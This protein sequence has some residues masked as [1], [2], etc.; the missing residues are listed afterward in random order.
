MVSTAFKVMLIVLRGM[1]LC[2]ILLVLFGTILQFNF[3]QQKRASVALLVD[4]SASLQISDKGT[5][6]SEVLQGILQ[7]SSLSDIRQTYTVYPYAFSDK[8]GSVNKAFSDSLSFQGR[9]TDLAR[10]LKSA[11]EPRSGDIPAAIILLSDGR[12][13]I[14]DN[15]ARIAG[16]LNLPVYSVGIGDTAKKSDIVITRVLSNDITYKDNLT[17]CEV[18]FQGYGFGGKKVSLRLKQ[19]GNIL[20]EKK[21][22][23]PSNNLETRVNF[24]FKLSETGINKLTLEVDQFAEELTGENN[25]RDF[26]IKVLESKI[27]ILLLAS[28]PS[29]DLTFLKRLL[30]TD[31]DVEL[32]VRTEKKSGGFYQGRFPDKAAFNQ[33]D[34]FL[35]L[36]FPSG[37][38]SSFVWNMVET[39]VKD[40]QK[41]FMFFAGRHFSIDKINSLQD[42]LPCTIERKLTVT[43]EPPVITQENRSHPLLMINHTTTVSSWNSLPPIFPAC[44]V[45]AIKP[46]DKVLCEFGE[47][48]SGRSSFPTK[49]LILVHQAAGD[50][51]LLFL[52]YGFYRWDLVMWGIGKTNQ[53]LQGF[54]G[55]ALRWLSVQEDDDR[56]I[57]KT[58]KFNFR[59]GEEVFFL[60]QAYD[61]AYEPLRG[62][63]VELSSTTPHTTE[64]L[65]LR[66]RGDGRYSE[67]KRFF[68][69]GKYTVSAEVYRDDQIVGKD[70]ESFSVDNFNPEFVNTR[71]DFK[72]LKSVSSLSGGKFFSIHNLDSLDQ[73][74]QFEPEQVE[75]TR[76][77]EFFQSPWV[78]VV[79]ILL[80]SLDWFL[81][82]RKGML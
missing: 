64:K 29:P 72:L 33:Y 71:A 40:E 27:S 41:P 60:V 34:L 52:G 18:F 10:A 44:R 2:L 48:Y 75:L 81:R 61:Q 74:I 66:D 9:G 37:N 56:V 42:Y 22:T 55:N 3:L 78:L 65:V 32:T 7:S 8:I 30:S 58:S 39:A 51:S 16:Q 20:G 70:E 1:A 59:A 68:E 49:P 77:L 17:S 62:A 73:Y 5:K 11:A 36:D 19:D 28:S 31:K 14:G 6:R 15:P 53:L 54:M 79:I 4:D 24:E 76:E 13:T 38:T 43:A 21:V 67:E 25:V 80:L 26:Y 46:N 45:S 57:L 35:L 63:K 23:I 12:Y 82:K 47:G 69:P 50:K